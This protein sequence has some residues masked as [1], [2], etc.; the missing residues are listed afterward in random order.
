MILQRG[1]LNCVYESLEGFLDAVFLIFFWSDVQICSIGAW[2]VDECE[3]LERLE[4]CTD[5]WCA[6]CK[7]DIHSVAELA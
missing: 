3:N 1:D 2:R 4:V 6:R 5:E 7:W